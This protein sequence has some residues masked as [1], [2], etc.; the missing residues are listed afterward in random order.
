MERLSWFARLFYSQFASCAGHARPNQAN[1]RAL[2]FVFGRRRRFRNVRDRSG[3]H[4]RRSQRVPHGVTRK[5]RPQQ[6][7]I[8]RGSLALIDP[9]TKTREFALQPHA[10]EIRLARLRKNMVERRFNMLVRHAALPKLPRNAKS[11]LPASQPVNAREFRGK[12]SI[13][14]IFILPEPR[15]NRFGVVS[16]LG[17]ALQQ[18]PHLIHRMRPPHQRA[19]SRS[20]KFRFRSKFSR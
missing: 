5:S 16:T 14:K 11:S 10:N 1:R 15:E 20:I 12:S 4:T 9:P 17:P 19:Q 13:I 3:V 8:K 18:L 6:P 7:A 2:L